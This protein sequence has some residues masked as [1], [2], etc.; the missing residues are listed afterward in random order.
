MLNRLSILLAAVTFVAL[1]CAIAAAQ[2]ASPSA[3]TR[4]A[5]KDDPAALRA[6]IHRTIAALIEARADEKPDPASIKELTEKIQSL[7]TRARQQGALGAMGPGW[8]GRG[9]GGA[10]MGMGPGPGWGGG[11][12]PCAGWGPGAARGPGF[13]RGFGAGAGAGWGRAFV[14]DDGNGICDNFE[15]VQGKK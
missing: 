2:E 5:E 7:R 15:R 13:G 4:S 3:K 11:R 6:E 10:G 9:R 12:G 1:S 8:A 14:D